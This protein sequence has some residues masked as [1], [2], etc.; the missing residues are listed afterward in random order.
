MQVVQDGTTDVDAHPAASPPSDGH[1]RQDPPSR[2]APSR[3]VVASS[4]VRRPR[5]ERDRDR[6]VAA[7]AEVVAD[8]VTG[9]VEPQMCRRHGY[10]RSDAG[11]RELVA[12]LTGST[13]APAAH[14]RQPHTLY[15]T[16]S[17]YYSQ[18]DLKSASNKVTALASC[19]HACAS[20]TK[21]YNFVPVYGR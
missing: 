20:V 6:L 16:F 8:D 13:R 1:R 10:V 21:Q 4:V 12:V 2:R 15:T 18:N 7:G 9:F 3:P 14:C 5:H 19:S 17:P 11:Q